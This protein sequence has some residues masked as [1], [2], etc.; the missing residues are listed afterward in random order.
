MKKGFTVVELSISVAILGSLLAVVAGVFTVA[1]KNY[2]LEKQKA[3]LQ[4]ELNYVADSLGNEIKNATGAPQNYDI[5][6]LSPTTLVLTLPSLD[7][8]ENFVYTSGQ[9]EKDYFVY[10]LSGQNLIKHVIPNPLSRRAPKVSTVLGNV[11]ALN[12]MYSPDVSNVSQIS[13]NINVSVPIGKSNA[14]S[15]AT[16]TA[17]L[18]NK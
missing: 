13:F 9:L 1:V 12:F 3:D 2:Q 4:K 14:K 16:R 17:N 18:R 5:Y 7:E 11:S 6:T 10:I 15:K 8:N